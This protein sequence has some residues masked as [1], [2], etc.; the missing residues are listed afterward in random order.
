M[1]T[2][3]F[4]AAHC[5]PPLT[6][7]PNRQITEYGRGAELPDWHGS[8]P[9]H[10]MVWYQCMSRLRLVEFGAGDVIVQEGAR[11]S[12]AYWLLTGGCVS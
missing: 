6:C 11:D 4:Q 9:R 12:Q 10:T 3:V 2:T 7:L 8:E 1:H 5:S